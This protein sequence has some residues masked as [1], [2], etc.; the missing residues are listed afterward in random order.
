MEMTVERRW[1]RDG[2][3][4]GVLSVN[5]KRFGNGKRYCSTLEDTDH[6]LS[7]DIA[8]VGIFKI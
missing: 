8:V 1:K 7:S 6:G 3:T 4:I 2:Y 5:G